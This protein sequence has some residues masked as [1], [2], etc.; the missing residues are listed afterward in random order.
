[1][2]NVAKK[3]R[4]AITRPASE[5]SIV[6]VS[7]DRKEFVCPIKVARMSSTI[8]GLLDD[9]GFDENSEVH[10]EH[11]PL[12]TIDGNILELILKWC[13]HHKVRN[14]IKT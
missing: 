5:R 1:M 6:L 8:R 11:I 12:A 13:E 14:L 9:L 3:P 10:G 7:S 2:A 4:E